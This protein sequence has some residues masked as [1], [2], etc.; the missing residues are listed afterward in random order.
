MIENVQ[1]FHLD[2]DQR[3]ESIKAY[4]KNVNERIL[5]GQEAREDPAFLLHLRSDAVDCVLVALYDQALREFKGS[6]RA[7]LVAQGGYGRRELCLRSDIDVILLY[8]GR[9]AEAFLKFVNQHVVQPLWDAGLEVGFAVRSLKDCRKLMEEDLTILTALLD[10]RHLAGDGALTVELKKTLDKYFSKSRRDDFRKR[11]IAENKE[12]HEKYGGAVSLLEPNVKESGGGLRDYHTLYWLAKVYDGVT[13]DAGLV[14]KGYLNASELSEMQ[15]C[16]RFLWRLRNELHRRTGRRSDQLIMESQEVV[17]QTLGYHNTPQFLGV[18]IFMQEYYQNT[19]ILHRLTE[20]AIR[21]LDRREPGLFP[22]PKIPLEDKNLS[23]VD[24]RLTLAH[25]DLFEREPMYLLKVFETA[26]KLELELD[27]WTQERAEGC[28]P[29][30]DD[31]FRENPEAIALFKDMLSRPLGLGK[32]LGAMNDTKVLGTFLPEFGKLHFRVQHNLY[33]AYTV[34]IHSLFAVSELGKIFRGD[35]EKA[36]GTL[37]QIVKDI[38]TDAKKALLAFAILY[39]D[40]GKG[41]GK[42][43]VERGAPI[44]RESARKLL[45]SEAEQDMLEALERSHL[46]MTHVAFRRDLEDQSMIIRFARTMQSLEFLDF[47]YVLTF[48]DVKAANPLAMTEWKASLLDYL[49]LKTREVLQHGNFTRE[50]ASV[51]LPPVQQEILG[52]FTEE[53][54]R[55]TARDFFSMMPARYLLSVPR[56]TVARH[57]KLWEGFEKNPIIFDIRTLEREGLHEVTLLTW[58]KPTLFSDMTGLFASHNLNI[59]EA[60]LHLSTRGHALHIFKLTD[61]AGGLV[62]PQDDKWKRVGKDLIEVLHGR[63]RIVNL[64]A[65]K[66]RP[67]LLRKKIAQ[68]KPAKVGIDNDVSAYYTVIDIYAEDRVGLLYQISS[69]LAALGL[70]VDVSKISTKLDQVAD[71][72]YVKDIFGHK[73]TSQERLN[74]IKEALKKVLE[75]EPQPGWRPLAN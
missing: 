12:R 28:L 24:G 4:L 58:E 73:I 63:V 56:A 42:G 5:R 3:I 25:Q 59:L 67:S 60:Q 68:V 72:F 21:R 44:I 53:K 69:T 30:I 29:R 64:V 38:A 10:A 11:K 40:I 65:E 49:Y 47:L 8:E 43:H 35:Y 31:A 1:E 41:D 36:H 15:R 34:D 33:H 22:A 16:L 45:F 9:G 14:K 7:A 62:D 66:F 46:I 2:T 32:M 6:L 74:K 54:D 18:E 23:I 37:T 51:L 70:Y 57:V 13:D 71:T 39:H 48:C 17:S 26:R 75:E 55:Q 50:T 27:D 19:A 20:R 61:Q 52:L